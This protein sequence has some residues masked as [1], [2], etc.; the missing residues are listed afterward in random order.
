MTGKQ[1]DDRKHGPIPTYEQ[2]AECRHGDSAYSSDG[3]NL[4]VQHVETPA[5]SDLYDA[6]WYKLLGIKGP[7]TIYR[8]LS[9]AISRLREISRMTTAYEVSLIE[10]G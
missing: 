4:A 6:A 5:D 8:N 3:A 9:K 1:E 10:S 2:I 7:V